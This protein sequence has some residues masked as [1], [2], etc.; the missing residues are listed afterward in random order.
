[1]ANNR[2][3]IVPRNNGWAVKREGNSKASATTSTKKQA[4]EIAKNYAIKCNGEVITHN[5]DGKISN[6]N[7]FGN[8]P[9]PP[10]DKIH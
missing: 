2:I 8:D 3:H 6:P 5:K 9:C 4:Y 10:K 1:M 7:S